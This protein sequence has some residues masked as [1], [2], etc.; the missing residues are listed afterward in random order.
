MN[1]KHEKTHWDID[2]SAYIDEC[3]GHGVYGNYIEQEIHDLLLDVCK[4]NADFA[5][6]HEGCFEVF[7]ADIG[8]T[9]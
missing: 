5:I 4:K 9:H 2:A 3:I 8:K 6:Q 1:G 7:G